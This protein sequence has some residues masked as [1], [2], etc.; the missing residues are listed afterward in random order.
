MCKLS[1]VCTSS[2]QQGH[3]HLL[4]SLASLWSD[5][6]HPR[7]QPIIFMLKFLIYITQLQEFL[8]SFGFA[9]CYYNLW[10]RR[11][12]YWQRSVLTRRWET[13]IVPGKSWSIFGSGQVTSLGAVLY[14]LLFCSSFA[15]NIL[16]LQGGDTKS[17]PGFEQEKVIQTQLGTIYGQRNLRNTQIMRNTQIFLSQFLSNQQRVTE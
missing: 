5:I 3:R 7:S 12:K 8:M 6:T 10:I 9:L 2:P 11:S 15:K 1:S 17:P 16:P 4:W 13:F 14:L